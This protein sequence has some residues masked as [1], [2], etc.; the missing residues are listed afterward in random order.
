MKKLLLV[1]TLALLVVG[2]VVTVAVARNGNGNGGKHLSAKLEGFSE[3]PAV[4]TAA[5]GRFK[6]K[7]RGSSIEYT[8]TYR[9]L[10]APVRFAHIHLGQ[11]DVAG[12]VAAFLCGGGGKP[13]CPQS[14]TVT[15][16]IN[17]SDVVGPA[18]QGIAAGEIGEL[19]RAIKHGVTYANVHSD[20]FPA[21]EIRGQIE[22]EDDDDDDD[23]RGRGNDDD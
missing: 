15:G 19:I 14:G 6:A 10:E 2:L 8:L 11:E 21:G 18:D 9:D 12:G 17:A 23:H 1:G 7:I 22:H 3:T 13:A 4:S 20:K 16:T 5:H